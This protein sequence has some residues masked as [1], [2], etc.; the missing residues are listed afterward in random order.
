MLN[1]PG[2]KE[3]K[4]GMEITRKRTGYGAY[5]PLY[6]NGI[7]TVGNEGKLF[8]L[9]F[10]PACKEKRQIMDS[11]EFDYRT[12]RP[13]RMEPERLYELSWQAFD[14][15][16]EL[17]WC[18]LDDHCL[19]GEVRFP[20]GMTLL[21]E[22]YIPREWRLQREWVNYTRQAEAGFAGE[23]ISPFHEDGNPALLFMTDRRPESAIGYNDRERQLEDFREKWVF[24]D[25]NRPD[26]W[27]DMGISRLMGIQFEKP[28]AFILKN[29]RA[30]RFLTLPEGEERKT[31][32]IRGSKELSRAAG[33]HC[34]TALS[35]NGVLAE[36]G[37]VFSAMPVYNAV[38]KEDTGRRYIM[39]DRPWSR[40]SDGWGIQ[41]N[42]DTFLSSWASAWTY[43]GLAME[44]MLSGYDVQLPDGKIPLYTTPAASGRAE[45]PITAGRAQH[46]VQGLTLW[47]TYLHTRDK[48]WASR[49]YEGARK[50]NAW[51]FSDRGDGQPRRDA[52]R[53]GLLGFGYDPEAEMGVLGAPLQPYVA[54]AQYAY[55][56]TYDDSPQWTSGKYFVSVAGMQDLTEE[57][58]EDESR[59]IH[60]YHMADIYTLERCCL[61]AAD[62]E[63]LGRMAR[64]LGKEEEAACYDRKMREITDRIHTHMWSEEDGCYYNLKFD[65][66]FSKRQSP[67]CFMPL[68]LQ[69]MP[70][71]RKERLLKILRDKKKFWGEYMIP[72]IA[73]DDPAYAG[74][75]Y[76]RGQIW[77]PQ[78][79]WTYLALKRAGEKELAWELAV[80]AARML[81]GE[82]KK[83]GFCPENYSGIT[84]ECSGSPHYNWGMLMGLPLLEEL[85][86]F[87]EDSVI[88]GNPLAPD[89]TSLKNVLVDGKRY[90]MRIE[91]GVTAVYQGDILVA[92]EKGCVRLERR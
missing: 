63:S 86:E 48:D 68:M 22:L 80:R 33:E 56:E 27:N 23:L 70:E 88:F 26:I 25:I 13:G 42:W 60:R 76:W 55:F 49:C 5:D 40:K 92:K 44:N 34:R 15:R 69:S 72:S 31:L 32:F 89:K 57:Q 28:F 11:A 51:W 6:P 8:G 85:V 87:R 66:T 82:W 10:L 78:T 58:V 14:Q 12:V 16:V 17:S 74:Q 50:A 62:C 39:V 90:D 30:E 38:Y 47:N 36:I 18:R 84:G 79:L 21:A 29:G 91:S 7:M 52:L 1:N 77:P 41:F 20:E 19:Y 71:G 4:D 24:R 35:G 59:Y 67:D 9:R 46:I 61:Y 65:G 2:R 75:H 53:K 81:A 43:P 83:N 54:K 45:P 64:A 73:K 37:Q 3:G